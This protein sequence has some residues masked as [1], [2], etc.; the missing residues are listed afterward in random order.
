[1]SASY[2][3]ALMQIFCIP[4]QEKKD[5]EYDNIETP[6]KPKKGLVDIYVEG[7]CVDDDMRQKFLDGWDRM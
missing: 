3:Y 5:T 2:K 1:M 4:T 6:L 7:G